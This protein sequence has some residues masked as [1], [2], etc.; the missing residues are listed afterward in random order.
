VWASADG[1]CWTDADGG[2]SCS[3]GA[4]VPSVRVS[5]I[6]RQSQRFS[7]LND[8]S[9]VSQ[10]SATP[11][12][13]AF[14][15]EPV[16]LLSVGVAAACVTLPT[17]A[18][19]Y[20]CFASVSGIPAESVTSNPAGFG[21]SPITDLRV[22]TSTVWWTNEAF[23][24]SYFGVLGC[25]GTQTYCS[26]LSVGDIGLAPIPVGQ[27]ARRVSPGFMQVCAVTP[28]SSLSCWGPMSTISGWQTLSSVWDVYVY[29]AGGCAVFES[30]TSATCWGSFSRTFPLLNG[31]ECAPCTVPTSIV[32][33]EA[34][35]PCAYGFETSVTDATVSQS[36]WCVPCDSVSVR[37]ATDSLCI[38]CGDGFVPNESLTDCLACPPFA[39]RKA[40]M[41]KCADCGIGSQSEP[42]GDA[43]TS[44]TMP[45]FRSLSMLS[46]SSC[47][48]G[49]APNDS[50]TACLA[51]PLPQYCSMASN[52]FPFS[53]CTCVTCP[54]GTQ[55]NGFGC[56]SCTAPSIRLSPSQTCYNCPAGTEPNASRTS[57]LPC[58]G[59]TVRTDPSP[60]CF[61]C[62]DLTE[63]NPSHTRCES[64]YRPPK[65][66]PMQY[67]FWGLGILLLLAAW[68]LS[69]FN[70]SAAATAGCLAV[71]C[72]AFGAAWPATLDKPKS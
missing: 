24:V 71:I 70:S 61:Q 65:I 62:P 44:C 36:A 43:C 17:S 14:P 49:A 16:G 10:S 50:Q 15:D 20:S 56:A 25:D 7:I 47:P 51:C 64:I 19:S 11:L 34:C 12:P 69:S 22:A 72:L 1:V 67:V 5:D 57:C 58:T 46:C 9:R 60:F 68:F 28:E 3:D 54:E 45:L 66:D 53:S 38:P 29:Q 63:P 33:N 35:V 4:S 8:V 32:L 26:S 30:F 18:S 48:S 13:F 59:N 52:L 23:S 42:A 39:Y 21:G 6:Q 41:V 37:G 40:P 2:A 27:Q 55:V 31:A